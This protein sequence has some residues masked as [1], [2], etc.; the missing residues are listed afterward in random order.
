M[1]LKHYTVCL[2]YC[3]DHIKLQSITIFTPQNFLKNDKNK[4]SIYLLCHIF[5]L[6]KRLTLN[7]HHA[8]TEEHPKL[9]QA[10]S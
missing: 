4:S 3:S 2:I 9:G 8:I 7:Q 10:G 6:L 1:E 5:K